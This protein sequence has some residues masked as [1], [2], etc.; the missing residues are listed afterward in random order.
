VLDGVSGSIESPGPDLDSDR[1]CPPGLLDKEDLLH[2]NNYYQLGSRELR[3]A[4]R[5][6]TGSAS[7]P[8][9]QGLAF[10]RKT[11][12]QEEVGESEL[13]IDESTSGILKRVEA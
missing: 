8:R 10:P 5:G 4:W 3:T 1:G 7:F 6:V 2:S 9:C 11:G 12:W 13:D